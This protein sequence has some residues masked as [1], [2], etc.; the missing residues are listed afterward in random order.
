MSDGI[1][2]PKISKNLVG[3]AGEYY[4]CAE[5]CRQGILALITPKNNPLIR[6]RAADPLGILIATSRF[7][8]AKFSPSEV[9]MNVCSKNS[10]SQC[11]KTPML[12]SPNGLVRR[13]L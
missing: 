2:P 13:W 5:L 1:S 6:H 7:E 4:V 10:R 3:V 9:N 11:S 8:A 12:D